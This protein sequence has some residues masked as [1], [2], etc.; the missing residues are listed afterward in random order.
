MQRES[1]IAFFAPF[2][3]HKRERYRKKPIKKVAHRKVVSHDGCAIKSKS[4]VDPSCQSR[5]RLEANLGGND[6]A[7]FQN[8]QAGDAVHAKLRG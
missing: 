6:L 4:P 5:F 8:H 3:S 1:G 7:S 2:F